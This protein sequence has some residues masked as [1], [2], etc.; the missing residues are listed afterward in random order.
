MDKFSRAL[1]FTLS[2]E[3]GYVNNPLDPGGATNMG[4]TQGVYNDFLQSKGF[5]PKNVKLIS[6]VEVHE[7]YKKRYWDQAG[8]ENMMQ[9]TS[10][11]VFDIAVNMGLGRVKAFLDDVRLHM[12][13]DPTN[14]AT[15]VAR[16]L[17]ELRIAFYFAIVK[18]K[19]KQKEFLKGWLNR[20]RA[21][22]RFCGF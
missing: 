17:L 11:V 13:G 6:A 16:R 20:T 7:I 9:P 21:L 3:G 1:G 14:D 10:T 2:W 18:Q 12:D 19:P 22:S 8:C 5:K 15:E 4:I